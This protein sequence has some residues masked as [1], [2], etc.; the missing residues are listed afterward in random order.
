MIS[1]AKTQ[2]LE[3]NYVFNSPLTAADT[4]DPIDTPPPPP[5]VNINVIDVIGDSREGLQVNHQVVKNR[6]GACVVVSLPLE[7][8]FVVQRGIRLPDKNLMN[9][10]SSSITRI[11]FHLYQPPSVVYPP[12]VSFLFGDTVKVHVLGWDGIPPSSLSILPILILLPA[13]V[14]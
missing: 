12:V 13:T 6:V 7:G 1:P 4:I 2:F 5:V 10:S 8:L 14:S 9:A 11:I 3:P